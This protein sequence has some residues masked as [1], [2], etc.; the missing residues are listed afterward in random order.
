MSAQTIGG[1]NGSATVFWHK[2]A[3]R[4]VR[5]GTALGDEAAS[6]TAWREHLARR[7]N[8]RRAGE[9]A[10]GEAMAPALGTAQRHCVPNCRRRGESGGA[11]AAASFHGQRP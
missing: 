3:P 5:R 2:S 10:A 9:S 7:R 8:A 4:P 6:W 1:S 11:A